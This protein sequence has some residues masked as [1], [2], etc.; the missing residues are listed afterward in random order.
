MLP[1][2]LPLYFLSGFC[3]LALETLWVR[4]LSVRIG[5]TVVT[6]T[7][8]LAAFFFCAAL[9]NLWG[10]RVVKQH[11]WPVRFYGLCEFL[12]ALSAAGLFP[13]RHVC[14]NA[15][16]HL[17]P[18]ATGGGMVGLHL[19]YTLLLVGVP[20]FFAGCT[21]PALAEACVT[22]TERRTR[23]GGAVYAFNL[24]GAALG[25]VGGGLLL[26][27]YLG[28]G[29]AFAVTIAVQCAIAGVAMLWARRRSAAPHEAAASDSASPLSPRFGLLLLAASGFLS[30]ML[31]MLVLSYFQQF[32]AASLYALSAVL[33]SFIVNLG[34]GSLLVAGLRAWGKRAEPLLLGV[35]TA[36]G[37]QLLCYPLLLQR[38]L[39]AGLLPPRD[40]LSAWTVHAILLATLLFAPLLITIGMVF[41]LGWELI[42]R[43]NAHHGEALGHAVAINKV[44]SALGAFCAPFV[45][46]PLLGL[47][48]AMMSAG[49]GYLALAAWGASRLCR[50]TPARLAYAGTLAVVLVVAVVTFTHRRSPL[51][52]NP[53]EHLLALYQGPDGVTAVT[54]D[55][56]HSRHIVLNQTYTLNGTQRALLSQQQE[57]WLPLLFCAQPERVAFIGMASGISA[58][59][60]LDFP[61]RDLTAVELVPE[62]A[63][64]AREQFR[65]W[66]D[67]LFT[68]RRAHLLVNDGRF[69][70]QDAPAKYDLVI[71]DLL[72]PTLD[73]TGSLYSREFFSAARDKL[74]PRG[75]FCLWLPMYQLDAELAGTVLRTFS[76][77]FPHAIIIRGNFDPLTPIVGLIGANDPID[78]STEF[79]ARRLALPAS[80][81]I[82]AHSPFFRSV[83][84]A[85]LS[86][87][88]DLSAIR[89]DFNRY[90][91]NTDNNQ[92]FSFLGA[93]RI[94]HGELLNGYPLLNYLGTRF[95]TAGHFSCLLGATPDSELVQ[96]M[97]AGN[98]YFA[99]GTANVNIPG[100]DIEQQ[101]Q[102]FRQTT[103]YLRKAQLL[104]PAAS[105][106][107]TDLGQ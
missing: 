24:L 46:V 91:P 104:D 75:A 36:G 26:P 9:G 65:S 38:G 43:G 67:A 78:L 51:V 76:D 45:L 103:G 90:P 41:P 79:L 81:R 2:L 94:E 21:F 33:F 63:R 87:I 58:A 89:G 62:V 30:L 7:L 47:P 3:T 61:V 16:H 31:E 105:L 6:A 74:A 96:G 42:E 77:V 92:R 88:G 69:I 11:A 34:I 15:V 82:A 1:L 107:A 73:G 54:E 106:G 22:H 66:N 57:G 68:D 102:R 32:T 55:A 86:F 97:R 48:G 25:V 56:E 84:N 99:A 39:T 59:A 93:K 98:Y 4:A 27:Y 64:A 17:A 12:S 80:R 50:Q 70:L 85:R 71:C 40:S 35:L 18:A 8:V 5:N 95:R 60:V 83:A 10:S 37:V 19:L 52:L 53:K 23:V 20:S 101:L 29:A 72:L 49:W 14:Y 44:G 100:E 28:N 13:L